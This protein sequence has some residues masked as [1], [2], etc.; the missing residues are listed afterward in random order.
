MKTIVVVIDATVDVQA[1]H[2]HEARLNNSNRVKGT[3]RK[4]NVTDG[5][6]LT[7][8]EKKMIGTLCATAPGRRRN[9]ARRTAKL[10]SLPINRPEPFDCDIFS[11]YCKDQCD[12][13]VFES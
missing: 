12:V 2:L 7:T 6:I 9:A 4:K 3:S 5:E 11:V 1:F 10:R 8:I 13:S